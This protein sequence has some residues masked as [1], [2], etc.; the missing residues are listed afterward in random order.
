MLHSLVSA[1]LL[2]RGNMKK[3]AVWESK[4]QLEY[5]LPCKVGIYLE[6]YDMFI[7]KQGSQNKS[8][9]REKYL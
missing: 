2:V 5:H 4:V 3:K 6:N 8:V 1:T 7:A 9:D